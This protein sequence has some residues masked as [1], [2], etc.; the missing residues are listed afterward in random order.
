MSKKGC[1]NIG[2]PYEPGEVISA[3]MN[4]YYIA[5]V[6]LLDG[7]AFIEQF[8]R[9]R[10]ADSEI[11]WL[12]PRIDIVHDPKLDIGGATKRHAV[13]ID[14]TLHSGEPLS[15]YVEQRRGSATHPLGLAEIDKKFRRLASTL[16]SEAK[17]SE[18]A[19]V[20]SRLDREPDLRRFTSLLAQG[21]PLAS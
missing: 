13:E 10:L 20:V 9:D 3:Q 16:L 17:I 1:L 6:T 11:L 19:D 21:S 7:D 4:G 8:A 5:A 12:M 18:L 2:W 14:A 15:V